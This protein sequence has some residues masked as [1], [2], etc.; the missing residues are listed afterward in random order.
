MFFSWLSYTSKH[1]L[2]VIHPRN[3]RRHLIKSMLLA[4][5]E[6]IPFFPYSFIHGNF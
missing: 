6:L 3:I 5:P 4:V 1:S 2:K